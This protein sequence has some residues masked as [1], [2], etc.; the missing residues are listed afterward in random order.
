MV[1]GERAICLTED[2]RRR[3][4]GDLQE[5]PLQVLVNTSLRLDVVSR[6][7]DH[8]TTRAEGEILRIR[9]RLGRTA[10]EIRQWIHRLQPVAIDAVGLTPVLTAMAHRLE[11]EWGTPITVADEGGEAAGLS[12]AVAMALY[13]AIQEAVINALRHAQADRILIQLTVVYGT[14]RCDVI[15]DGR[16]FD[17]Q[18]RQPGRYGLVHMR[19]WMELIG[20]RVFVDALPGQP[21]TRL[22]LSLPYAD[23]AKLDPV[24]EE[25]T[26]RS[27][28]ERERFEP[29]NLGLV[30]A[31]DCSV[32]G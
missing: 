20:G 23:V 24:F 26:H 30:P 10:M 8:D 21:G 19:Q 32:T 13:R 7:L 18:Q 14:L 3:F 4:A 1:D 15:D 28:G 31:N 16:G 2:A 5:G 22:R 27:A 6:L 25:A 9:R 12:P 17:P 11:E 29:S